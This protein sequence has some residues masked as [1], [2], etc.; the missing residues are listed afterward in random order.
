MKSFED[1]EPKKRGRPRKLKDSE[2]KAL[3]RQELLRAREEY[4]RTV[5]KNIFKRNIGSGQI[6]IQSRAK[7]HNLSIIVKD[8]DE[9]TERIRRCVETYEKYKKKTNCFIICNRY[10]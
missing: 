3:E 5:N 9:D 6:S 10:E 4:N 7:N 2:L 1:Q 8:W